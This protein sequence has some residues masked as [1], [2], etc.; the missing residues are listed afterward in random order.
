MMEDPGIG[1]RSQAAT[2]WTAWE[3]AVIS[4]ESNGSPGAYGD[5]A[6][7]AKLAF[8]RICSPDLGACAHGQP[9]RVGLRHGQAP[10][11][12]HQGAGSRAAG[13]AMAFNIH[14]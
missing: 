11:Q 14:R 2:E 9:D 6:D 8:V 13:L 4:Q 5:R 12:G 1:V 7:D 3:D 10:H